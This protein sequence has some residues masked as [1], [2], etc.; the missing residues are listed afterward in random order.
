[1]ILFMYQ[2]AIYLLLYFDVFPPIK[3]N[4]QL[5]FITY[6]QKYELPDVIVQYYYDTYTKNWLRLLLSLTLNPIYYASYISLESISMMRLYQSV[7]LLWM[8]FMFN[9]VMWLILQ[10]ILN[11]WYLLSTMSIPL[12]FYHVK[13]SKNYY[14]PLLLSYIQLR[15]LMSHLC[16]LIVGIPQIEPSSI[17]VQLLNSNSVLL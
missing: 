5:Y 9:L 12:L 14:M 10:S 7:P 13:L 17:W 11:I 8:W 15:I 16:H 4:F 1:M 2:L 3:F 6:K